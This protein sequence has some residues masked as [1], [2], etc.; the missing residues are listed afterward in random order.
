[1]GCRT[2]NRGKTKYLVLDGFD[3]EFYLM[4]DASEDPETPEAKGKVDILVAEIGSS[5]HDSETKTRVAINVG[6]Q[7]LKEFMFA[8]GASRFSEQTQRALFAID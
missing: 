8:L 6:A 1:M 7:R 4:F 3:S 5:P 2:S